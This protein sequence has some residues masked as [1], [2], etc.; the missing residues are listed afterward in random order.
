MSK[1]RDNTIVSLIELLQNPGCM[2]LTENDSFFDMAPRKEIYK[3]AKTISCRIFGAN[4]SN[5][6]YAGETG[7]IE[8][9]KEYSTKELSLQ[10]QLNFSI[11]ESLKEIESPNADK[12]QTLVLKI[13]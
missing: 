12:F 11:M 1:R 4:N 9:I 13:K 3:L 10:Q 5:N 2:S 7:E 8:S 6:N